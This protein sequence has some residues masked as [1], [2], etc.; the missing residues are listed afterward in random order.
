MLLVAD[1]KFPLILGM[2]DEG[3]FITRVRSNIMQSS[4]GS[5]TLDNSRNNEALTLIR[6]KPK[7]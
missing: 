2:D 5:F 6:F 4:E 7:F 3:N 1:N